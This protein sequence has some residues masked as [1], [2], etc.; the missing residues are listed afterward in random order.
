MACIT[1]ISWAQWH[2][3][4]ILALWRLRQEDQEF[5]GSLGNTARPL[6]QKPRK[7]KNKKERKDCLTWKLEVQS[8]GVGK[9]RFLL[10][11]DRERDLLQA[12]LLS[13]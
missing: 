5:E 12:S 4:I 7:N 8:E 2:K 3:S 10:R 6:F 1:K 11:A 9:G 13:L